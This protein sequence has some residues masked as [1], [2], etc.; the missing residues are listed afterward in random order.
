MAAAPGAG[1]DVR[2]FGLSPAREWTSSRAMQMPLSRSGSAGWS[3]NVEMKT[4]PGEGP[5]DKAAADNERVGHAAAIP[6]RPE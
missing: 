2:A 6:K 5:T 1:D 4:A 3:T